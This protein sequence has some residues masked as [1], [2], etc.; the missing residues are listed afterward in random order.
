[1]RSGEGKTEEESGGHNAC[2]MLDR[3]TESG[4]SKRFLAQVRTAW[5]RGGKSTLGN[6][7]VW[8][9]RTAYSVQTW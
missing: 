7:W 2:Q 3:S 6:G 9:V 5:A 1:M 4:C 8:C